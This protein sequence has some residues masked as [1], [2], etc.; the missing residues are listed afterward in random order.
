[1]TWKHK[2]L[3][4]EYRPVYRL[5]VEINLN[6]IY[7]VP[8]PGLTNCFIEGFTIPFSHFRLLSC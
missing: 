5:T 8:G 7:P 6:Q 4:N 2:C 3:I 1:M